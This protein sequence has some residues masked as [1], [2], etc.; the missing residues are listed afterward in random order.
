VWGRQDHQMKPAYGQRLADDIPGARLTWVDDAGHFVPADRP[1]VV[2]E[3][4]L[5]LVRE[6]GR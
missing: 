4:V 1:D 3:A 2:S 6:A 5:R